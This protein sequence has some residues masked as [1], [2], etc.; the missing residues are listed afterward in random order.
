MTCKECIGSSNPIKGIGSKSPKVVFVGDYPSSY[1]QRAGIPFSGKPGQLMQGVLDTLKIPDED[2]YFTNIFK[3]VLEAD[4]PPSAS[5]VKF[6]MPVLEKE[7]AKLNP[8]YIVALGKIPSL[9]LFPGTSIHNDRGKMMESTLGIPGLITYNPKAVIAYKGDTQL[10]YIVSDI[11]KVWRQII[12]TAIP[13]KWTEP[14]TA[15]FLINTDDEMI[16]LLDRLESLEDNT[17]VCLDWETTGLTPWKDTHFCLGISWREGTGVAIDG[18]LVRKYRK[19]LRTELERFQLTGFNCALFDYQF[20]KVLD[21]HPEFTHDAMLLH[22]M[23]DERPQQ[24]S[25]E[26]LTMLELDAPAYETEMMAL[27]DVQKKDMIEKIPKEEV[28]VYCAKDVD[29][30]LRLTKFLLEQVEGDDGLLYAY[31]NIVMP[32]AHVLGDLRRV[33]IWVNQERL[34]EVKEQL[35]TEQ[36]ESL[37]SLRNLTKIEDF[38]PQSHVQV[39]DYLWDELK[40]EEPRIFKRK[41]RSA[42]AETL[43]HL[44][45][46]PEAKEFVTELSAYRKITTYLTRYITNLSIYID[47]SGRV[48]PDIHIDRTETGRLSI[49]KPPLHQ[50]PREGI[51]RTIFGAPPGYQLLQADYAQ[52]EIR[53]AAHVG[54]DETLTELLLSGEDFH[55]KMAS[56]AFGVPV[57]MITK[58]QRQA[59]KAVSFG[60]LY[61]MSEE[62]LASNT[63]LPFKKAKEFVKRYKSLMPGVQEAITDIKYKVGKYGEVT[64]M[65]GRKRRFPYRTRDNINGLEREAVNFALGQSPGSDITLNATQLLHHMLQEYF[66]EAKIVLTVHDSIL[67]ECPDALVQ[68]VA[69]LMFYVMEDCLS[70]KTKVPFPIELK[71]GRQWGTGEELLRKNL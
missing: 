15:A 71:V 21:L 26:K 66:P 58:E 28:M 20:S 1:D 34:A 29:W 9:R 57:S 3:C 56:E 53:V 68:P 45:E 4:R 43:E 8:Q 10:P 67:V 41:P 5:E 30:A 50:I 44:I 51:I 6:C 63:G 55:T 47:S 16:D 64:S 61:L 32:A 48:H 33:G 40:L 14:E 18:L 62:K 49:T 31:T 11:K 42:N 38:N 7:I 25:Q 37:Q 46:I 59:A 36:Q 69:K 13:E 65:F 70:F 27:H 39:Q 2:V 60:L 23:T 12:G 54:K 24:R 52:L 19:E 35:E 22:Y 17:M